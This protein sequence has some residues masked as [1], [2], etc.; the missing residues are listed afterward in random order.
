MILSS[1]QDMEVA[2]MKS[3]WY[4]C[5]ERLYQLT[6]Q[7]GW[8]KF[9][10]DPSLDEEL[11]EAMA[12]VGGRTSCSFFVCLIFFQWELQSLVISTNHMQTRVAMSGLCRFCV[13]VYVHVYITKVSVSEGVM[14]LRGGWRVTRTGGHGRGGWT[15]ADNVRLCMNPSKKWNY[16]LDGN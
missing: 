5:L 15:D 11:Q 12:A 6:C 10:R 8:R 4:G 13:F 2:N 14:N 3:Q 16:H 1:E 9:H 7:H